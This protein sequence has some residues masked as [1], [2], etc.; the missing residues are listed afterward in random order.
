MRSPLL[1]PVWLVAHVLVLVVLVTFPLLGLWQLDRHEQRQATDAALAQRPE[2]PA[3]SAGELDG[4]PDELA[5]RR[6]AVTGTWEPDEEVLLST[7]PYQGRPGH[8]VLTPLRLEDGS[9]VLVDRGWVPYEHDGVPV[10]A[11]A[12]PDGPVEVTGLALPREPAHRAGVL[13]GDGRDPDELA[14]GEPVEF[15]S[16]ADP[17]VVG[18]AIDEDLPALVVRADG[19]HRRSGAELPASVPPPEPDE[20]VDHFSY[21]MQWF[22]F[23]GVVAIGYPVLL[24][25]RR[26]DGGLGS[27]PEPP[28]AAP[29]SDAAATPAGGGEREP[30][31]PERTGTA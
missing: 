16:H 12:P 30:G 31:R 27:E 23:T 11:A 6:V 25:R 19:G 28:E 22:A 8:H 15:V 10:Q 26:R 17:A 14:P 2:Q 1:S 21:A 9:A 20:G 7:R 18:R 29:A 24:R 13:G 3:L 4:D 5:Y